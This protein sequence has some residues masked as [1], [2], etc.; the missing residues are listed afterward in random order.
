MLVLVGSVCT[1][2]GA[3]GG[4]VERSHVGGDVLQRC[5]CNRQ[6]K[7]LCLWTVVWEDFEIKC[8]YLGI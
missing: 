6:H 2:Q 1:L 7:A 8:M 3:V 4:L 5:S